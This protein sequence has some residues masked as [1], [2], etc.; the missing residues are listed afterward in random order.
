MNKKQEMLKNAL[1]KLDE[2]YIAEGAEIAPE[3]EN[4]KP[5]GEK[6]SGNIAFVLAAVA[7]VVCCI[8]GVSAVSEKGLKEIPVDPVSS[9]AAASN[10]D[11]EQET[12]NRLLNE[13]E[14]MIAMLT[15]KKDV[16]QGTLN[17]TEKEITAL[18]AERDLISAA[19][20]SEINTPEAEEYNAAQIENYN[21]LIFQKEV[22][23]ELLKADVDEIRQEISENEQKKDEILRKLGTAEAEDMPVETTAATKTEADEAVIFPP[24]EGEG[25]L[26]DTVIDESIEP[27]EFDTLIGEDENIFF[28]LT[29]PVEPMAITVYF[30]YN[31][32]TKSF[33][34]GI[35]VGGE[36]FHGK[37]VYAAADGVVEGAYSEYSAP[38]DI[39]RYIVIRHEN[40]YATTYCHL[41]EMN[42]TEG[43]EV[44]SGEVIGKVGNTGWT[45]GDCLTFMLQDGN[46]EYLDPAIY[47]GGIDRKLTVE[48]LEKLIREKAESLSWAD[49]DGYRYNEGGSGLCIRFYDIGAGLSVSIG[50]IPDKEPMYIYLNYIENGESK[51]IEIRESE[52]KALEILKR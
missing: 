7:A 36:D 50:G 42:V 23:A 19:S 32:W 46:G 25:G 41:D 43:Q 10:P 27:D 4:V 34:N 28:T 24:F 2:G 35:C 39:G 16:K 44:K 45:T 49:F 26:V 13:T 47:L 5:A 14:R 1:D 11:S 20:K 18:E 51:N 30:G 8:V 37:D 12:L 9:G 31:D 48:A 22:E 21:Q 3:K 40:G 38:Y 29:N 52:E 15:A 17:E 6:K 33:S